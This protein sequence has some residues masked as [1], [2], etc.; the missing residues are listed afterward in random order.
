MIFITLLFMKKLRESQDSKVKIDKVFEEEEEVSRN[1]KLTNFY[2]NHR[3][4][5]V[6]LKSRLEQF[7]KNHHQTLPPPCKV[8]KISKEIDIEVRP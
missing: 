4:N 6:E 2:S 8:E 5:L 1:F 7:K 3:L